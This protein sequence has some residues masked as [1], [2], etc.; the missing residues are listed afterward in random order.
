MTLVHPPTPYVEH[1]LHILKA[2]GYR[3]TQPRRL[4]L[5]LLDQATQPL[6][7]YEIKEQ[8][9]HAGESVDTV[10]IYRIIKCLED[11]G[12]THRVMTTGKIL[13]CRLECHEHDPTPHCEHDHNAHH[14]HH[15]FICTQCGITQEIHCTGIDTLIPAIE[16]AGQFQIERHSLEFFGRCNTCLQP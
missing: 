15:L 7:A 9:D 11:C 13:K 10:S 8:L 6:S 5:E 4:V 14:C 16:Q 2:S 1:A 12:L 3:A